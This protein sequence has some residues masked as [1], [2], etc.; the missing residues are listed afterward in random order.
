MDRPLDHVIKAY[1]EKNVKELLELFL[2]A[3]PS[4][5]REGGHSQGQG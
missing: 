2:G 3:S 1:Q 4:P 5:G